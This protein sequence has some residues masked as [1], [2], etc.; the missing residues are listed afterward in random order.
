M[1][2][3]K[4]SR[5][6]HP[7]RARPRL[8]RGKQEGSEERECKRGWHVPALPPWAPTFSIQQPSDPQALGDLKGLL[9]VLPVTLDLHP[10]HV[11]QIWPARDA[12]ESH[13]APGG[14]A[15]A[16]WMGIAAVGGS[17]VGLSPMGALQGIW[18]AGIPS[19]IPLRKGFRLQRKSSWSQ[20]GKRE[21]REV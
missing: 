19:L 7:E 9:Q 14:Q 5:I 12:P 13:P 2:T 6:S 4:L 21:P 11:H 15:R 18:D 8:A 20:L 1:K 16:S 17:E 3:R 10:L